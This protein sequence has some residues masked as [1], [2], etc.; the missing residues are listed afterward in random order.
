MQ[1]RLV[2][3]D[4][5]GEYEKL[6]KVFEKSGFDYEN[7]FLIQL[8]DVVDRGKDSFKVIEELLKVKNREFLKGNHDDMFYQDLKKGLPLPLFTQVA[9]QTLESYIRECAP[10]RYLKMNSLY[11][12]ESDFVHSDM[13]KSHIDFFENQKLYYI[14]DNMCFVHGGFNRHYPIAGQDELE[15]IWDRDLLASARSYASSAIGIFKIKDGFSKV[16]LGHTPVQAF[17][18]STPQKYGPIIATD[19]GSGK[20]GV[21]TIMDIDTEEYWQSK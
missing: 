3:S 1:R 7:D 19:T 15:L 8:G 5:H 2:L 9:K 18:E 13:P 4:I 16:F 17:G 21:L 10:H 20:G 12:Y 11:T 14:L 6:L